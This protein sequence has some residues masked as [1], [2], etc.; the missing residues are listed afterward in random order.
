MPSRAWAWPWMECPAPLAATVTLL[1]DEPERKLRSREIS[2]EDG[3]FSTAD[4][5]WKSIL[6]KSLDTVAVEGCRFKGPKSMGLCMNL[7][8]E[9]RDRTRMIRLTLVQTMASSMARAILGAAFGRNMEGG[10]S[11]GDVCV[12]LVCHHNV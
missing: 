11:R 12:I 4:G 6:P 8:G 10:K 1:R 5:A 2:L 7:Y 3:G 9:H